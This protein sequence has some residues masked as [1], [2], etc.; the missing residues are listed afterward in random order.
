[1]ST[2]NHDSLG[3][4][5]PPQS[6]HFSDNDEDDNKPVF[7]TSIRFNDESFLLDIPDDK[8]VADLKS[9]LQLYTQ[10]QPIQMRLIIKGRICQDS[11]LISTFGNLFMQNNKVDSED[12]FTLVKINN[13]SNNNNNTNNLNNNSEN[14]QSQPMDK[15]Y[16]SNMMKMMSTMM[17]NPSFQVLFGFIF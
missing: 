7:I 6:P 12:T 10:L 2:S 16:D 8:T 5:Y 9:K 15:G 13:N 14:S 1:M 4:E 17:K 3:D 11:E